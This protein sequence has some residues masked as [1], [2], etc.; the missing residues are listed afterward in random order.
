[1]GSEQTQL[2]GLPSASADLSVSADTSAS[3]GLR[4]PAE[5][6]ADA[7]WEGAPDRLDRVVPALGLA[8][9]RSQATEL[10]AAGGVR[11]DGATASKS[12]LRIAPGSRI[13]VS[14]SDHYVGRA[15]HKL[16]AGLD[17]FGLDAQGSVALDIGASTGGFT[18][19]LLE[20]G[21][22]AVLAIDVGRDQLA[23]ELREDDRVHLVEGRNAR[24][25]TPENLAADTGIAEAP[26]LVVADLSFIS[27]GLVFPAIA[28]CAAADAELVLLVKPQFEVGRVRD[29]VVTSPALWAEAM[30]IVLRAAHASG[31]AAQALAASPISGGQG[32]REFL[33]HF[34]RGSA[35]LPTEW[36]GRIAE[37]TG[38]PRLG[39]APGASGENGAQ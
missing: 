25:L 33:A 15:A 5:T 23:S 26:N 38:A 28:K 10:I 19:V 16:I 14:G 11:V 18:Q 2:S 22:R 4:A 3:A 1:M 34:S 17:A 30:R 12:G 27:L 36:E 37:L 29:G 6:P 20:R 39:E 9:S 8:R 24:D 31:F 13:S 35:P 21:A 32:N 7:V